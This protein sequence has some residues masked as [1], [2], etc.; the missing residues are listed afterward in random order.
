MKR[1]CFQ[2]KRKFGTMLLLRLWLQSLSAGA[3]AAA[4][5]AAAVAPAN[6]ITS[7]FKLKWR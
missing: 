2:Q 5:T 1:S 4:D 3:V 7:S 6:G